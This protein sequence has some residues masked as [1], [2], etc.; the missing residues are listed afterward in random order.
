MIHVS[1]V[2]AFPI[3]FGLAVQALAVASPTRG[4][5]RGAY[6]LLA[7]VSNGTPT[8][9]AFSATGFVPP[10]SGQAA[11]VA[12]PPDQIALVATRQATQVTNGFE[13][14]ATAPTVTRSGQFAALRMR[15]V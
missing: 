10:I 12:A 9:T 1:L 6:F 3:L 7:L 14:S 8:I 11:T 13:G 2:E 15:A 4:S 5:G